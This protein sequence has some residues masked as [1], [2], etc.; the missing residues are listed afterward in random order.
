[1]KPK[2]IIETIAVG[3]EEILEV[4]PIVLMTMRERLSPRKPFS[5]QNNDHLKDQIENEK[6]MRGE[7]K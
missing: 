7:T 2:I 1:M 5:Y 3:Q 4:D 6:R